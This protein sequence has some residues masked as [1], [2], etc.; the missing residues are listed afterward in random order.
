M[1]RRD[2]HMVL[3]GKPGRKRKLGKPRR[4]WGYNIKRDLKEIVLGGINWIHLAQYSDQWRAAV[5]TVTNL[6]VTYNFGKFLSSYT[7]GGFSRSAHL[8]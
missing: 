6:R 7:T 4:R 2:M 3:M 8:R 5:N 1:G